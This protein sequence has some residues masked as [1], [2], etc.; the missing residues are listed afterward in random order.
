MTQRAFRADSKN[1]CAYDNCDGHPGD[2]WEWGVI[3]K[4]NCDYPTI[5]TRGKE[6]P[7]Y[8]DGKFINLRRAGYDADTFPHLPYNC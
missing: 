6:Y 3:Q 8:G 7:L 4:L 2:V 1:S 5:T